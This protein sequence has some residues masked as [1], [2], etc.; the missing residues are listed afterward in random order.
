MKKLL[1]IFI[2]ILS[3]NTAFSQKK[4]SIDPLFKF[5]IYTNKGMKVYDPNIKY[6]P[7]LR[8]EIDRKVDYHINT[9]FRVNYLKFSL[10]SE[11]VFYVATD[12]FMSNYPYSAHF[13][14]RA[15]YKYN[16]FKLGYEHLCIHPISSDVELNYHIIGEYDEFFISY[17]F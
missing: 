1:I 8:Y 15:Y 14:I 11:N 12:N 9:G 6:K 16:K 13:F 17:G 10:E 3:F 7:A 4:F 2:C 5:G